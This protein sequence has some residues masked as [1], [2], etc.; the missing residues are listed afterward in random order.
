M[1]P[2]GIGLPD[3]AAATALVEAKKAETDVLLQQVGQESAIADEQAELGAI[4][5]EK[6]GA[7]QQEVSAF[8]AQCNADLAAT[9]AAGHSAAA[10]G[11]AIA[12]GRERAVRRL[13]PDDYARMNTG[14]E[15]PPPCPV[16]QA[17]LEQ[18]LGTMWRRHADTQLHR[19]HTCSQRRQL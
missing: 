14:Y 7:I 10:L 15:L 18:L 16:K 12:A 4:E 11:A 2:V 6:V 8:A 13:R 1:G 3:E 9:D 17:R 5:A 19:D